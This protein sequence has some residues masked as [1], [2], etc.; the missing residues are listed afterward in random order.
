MPISLGAGITIAQHANILHTTAMLNPYAATRVY[1]ARG[2]TDQDLTDGLAFVDMPDMS[3]T[4]EITENNTPVLVVFSC[5]SYFLN[6]QAPEYRLMNI[7]SSGWGGGKGNYN[8][9]NSTGGWNSGLSA[10]F[11]MAV[12]NHV[13]KVQWKCPAAGTIHNHC[14]TAPDLHHRHLIAIVFKR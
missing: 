12:G 14:N 2:Q 9:S 11:P 8:N 3:V 13:I 4:V 1:S 7:G 10:I 6:N 5:V